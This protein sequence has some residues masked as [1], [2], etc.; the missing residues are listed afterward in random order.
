M[1]MPRPFR[2]KVLDKLTDLIKTITP[3]NGY[4]NDMSVPDSVVRGRVFIGDNEPCPMVSLIEPPA[5]IEGIR[6]QSDN[7]SRFGEW[8]ILV[9]GWVPDDRRNPT[10]RAYTLAFEVVKVLAAEK[11][12]PVRPGTG[13]QR[14]YLGFAGKIQDMRIGAPVIRPPDETSAKACFYLL[15]TLQ[16]A[17]DMSD[18]FS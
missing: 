14:D 16:I 9:Q 15:L 7:P 10:D 13:G 4:F 17:E 5:A 12:K 3:A 11:K 1:T 8:D 2:L 18:P 6:T